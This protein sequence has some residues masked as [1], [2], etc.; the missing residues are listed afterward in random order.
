MEKEPTPIDGQKAEIFKALLEKPTR[1]FIEVINNKSLPES[2]KKREEICFEIKPPVLSTLAKA[3]EISNALP[4]MARDASITG[5]NL[6]Q[7]SKEMCEIIAIFSHGSSKKPM[8]EWYVP[9]LMDNL[10]PVEVLNI[11][12]ETTFKLRTDFFLTSFQ[13]ASQVN[14]MMMREVPNQK[15]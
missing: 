15:E 2:L 6:M 11:F 10:N 9:F 12:Q 3:A 7:Y 1:Y 5:G 8:P 4:D 13:I 14:P